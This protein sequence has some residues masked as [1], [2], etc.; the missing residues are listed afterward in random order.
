[1]LRGI[2][3]GLALGVAL[4]AAELFVRVADRY[5]LI[6]E[7]KEARHARANSI[8]IKSA[9]PAIIYQHRP[10]YWRNAIRYTERHGILRPTDA[11][12]ERV[13]GT[14]RVV[15]LGDSVA[16]AIALPYRRRVFTLVE[17]GLSGPEGR[18]AEVLNFGV[19]GY[20]TSQEAAMLEEIVAPFTPDMIILQYCINDFTPAA[21]FRDPPSLLV[22]LVAS[23]YDRSVIYGYPDA[24]YFEE[25]YRTDERGWS[26][27]RTGLAKIGG[28]SR[29]RSIPALLVIF[30][31]FER[32]GWHRGAASRRHAQVQ[33]LG[34][35]SGFE[36]LDLLP[37]YDKYPVGKIRH[38][39]WDNLHPNELGHRLAAEAI[40]RKLTQMSIGSVE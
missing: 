14:F 8:W 19:N 5:G 20:S 36:V 7:R 6:E 2:A 39:R 11:P 16:A 26:N 32:T 37:V 31:L 12:R 21:W 27:V 38:E 28:Y 15:V 17:Q 18:Q 23:R 34:Q 29:S 24:S 35:S 10:N 3:L 22:D 1:M 4:A 9:N 40:L 25:Q 13:P 30:P 33:Q